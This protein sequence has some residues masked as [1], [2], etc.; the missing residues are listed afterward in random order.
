MKELII[1]QSI[2]SLR[3][4]GLKFS[5]DTVA[6]ALN[7]SKKTIYKYFPD[8]Q[9]LAIALYERYYADIFT[10]ISGIE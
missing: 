5:V 7:I 6:K 9:S 3:R 2:D 1:T 8:K 4:E 10:R